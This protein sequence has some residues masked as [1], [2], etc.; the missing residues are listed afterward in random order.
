[1]IADML[2]HNRGQASQVGHLRACKQFR[3]WLGRPPETAEPDDVLDF[4]QRHKTHDRA[5]KTS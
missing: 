5:I 4:P 3:T 1:M 2:A